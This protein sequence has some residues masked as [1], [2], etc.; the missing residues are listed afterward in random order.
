[1]GTGG[2]KNRTTSRY[3]RYD[4][5]PCGEAVVGCQ[6]F[7]DEAMGQNGAEIGINLKNFENS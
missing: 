3:I 4:S 2:D 7:L 5:H 6:V 1:M